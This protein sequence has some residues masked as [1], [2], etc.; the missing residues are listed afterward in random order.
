MHVLQEITSKANI[1]SE[2]RV[3]LLE[4]LQQLTY[5]RTEGDYADLRASHQE[6]GGSVTNYFN[7]N[8]D[9]IREE[10][11]EAFKRKTQNFGNRTTNRI[12]SFLQKKKSNRLL[13]LEPH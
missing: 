7:T 13:R 11:C 10:W 5:A 6:F 12:E 9:P 1:N 3:R 4:I 8:W 2:E